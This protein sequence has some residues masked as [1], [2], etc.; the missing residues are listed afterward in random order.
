MIVRIVYE[1]TRIASFYASC[2]LPQEK[3]KTGKNA[4]PAIIGQDGESP[5]KEMCGSKQFPHI[6]NLG[7]Q[8]LFQVSTRN[9]TE[10]VTTSTINKPT[11]NIPLS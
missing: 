4:S 10:L 1:S 2:E 11:Q 9:T 8:D 7:L 6:Y 3:V 5:G